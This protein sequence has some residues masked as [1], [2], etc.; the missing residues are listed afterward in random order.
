MCVFVF[1]ASDN[2]PK[3]DEIRTL[4]KDLW[5]TRIAKLRLSADKFISQLE[6]HAKVKLAVEVHTLRSY[7][8]VTIKQFISQ[9]A[10]N[11]SAFFFFKQ[12][13]HKL[14]SYIFFIVDQFIQKM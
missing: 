12:K 14:L 13:C 1:S 11:Y 4:V 8:S 5:D 3:A 10:E 2:I 9:L 7:R 6:A